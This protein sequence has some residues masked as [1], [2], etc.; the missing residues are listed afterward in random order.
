MPEATP[1][2]RKPLPTISSLNEPYWR[3]LKRRELT[4]QQCNECGRIW[5]PPAP[6]CPQCWSR[7]IAW[8][9]LSGRGRVNSWVVFHQ[10][11]FDSY[12]Q[13]VPYNVVE[14]ELDE[15]P[16]ILA[17]LVGIANS[18][19]SAGLPVEVVFDDVTDEITL[20]KF[21]PTSS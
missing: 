9:R 7:D 11:Y 2:Y 18:E 15:G 16:R 12:Q 21:K 10:A 14:I 5:Y 4:M 3:A 17:N 8:K 1:R 20:A 13:D 19:I 6:L